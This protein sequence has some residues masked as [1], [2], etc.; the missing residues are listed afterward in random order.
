MGSAVLDLREMGQ[1]VFTLIGLNES[2]KTTILEAIDFFGNNADEIESLYGAKRP[3]RIASIV[4]KHLKANFTGEVSVTAE[5]EFEGSERETIVDSVESETGIRLDMSCLPQ[6]FRIKRFYRY[7]NSDFKKHHYSW[8]VSLKGRAKGERKSK[9]VEFTSKAGKAFAAEVQKLLPKIVY[10]PTF[11]FAIPDKIYLNGE[12]SE[13][14]P[15]NRHFKQIVQDLGAALHAPL[16]LKAHIVD[17]ILGEDASILSF[18]KQQQINAV[19]NN[20]SAHLTR[21]IF[22]SWGR[23]FSGDFS[24][25]EIVL[26][27]GVDGDANSRIVY[28]Y[29]VL[30]EGTTEYAV[31]ERSLGFRWF[32]AFLLFTYYRVYGKVRGHTLFLLDEPASNLHS[33][34]Q[35]QLLESFAKIADRSNCIMYS[36]HSHYLINPEW[37]EQAFV[38]ANTAIDYEQ[39]REVSQPT[40]IVVSRYRAFVGENPDKMT[41]FQPVLD[42]LEVAPSRLDLTRPSVLVEGKGDYFILEY[43]RRVILESSSP[44]LVVPTRGASSMEDLIGLLSGW[45]VQFAVCLDGDKAGNDAAKLICEDWGIDPRRVFTLQALDGELKNPKIETLL[46]KSDKAIIAAY[47]K[48]SGTPTKKQIQYFFSEMLAKREKV[49]LSEAFVSRIRK[50]EDFIATLF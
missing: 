36:T 27:Y 29:F 25:R 28:L 10:F 6:T 32:F 18:D 33:R 38:V 1:N 45:G 50:F 26:R 49:E 39:G 47:L 24:G 21:T 46:E 22:G 11:L 8:F 4:P 20:M 12:E 2:G 9:S 19:L 7:E 42:R 15:V 37:L 40:D 16:E 5:L 31:S 3:K 23:I 48:V 30:K 35:M 34:A 41:Y 17:R 13:T 14:D 43:A 44:V